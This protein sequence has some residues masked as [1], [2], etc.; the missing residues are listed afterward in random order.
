MVD[1]TGELGDE[2]EEAVSVDIFQQIKM[3][4]SLWSQNNKQFPLNFNLKKANPQIIKSVSDNR[5][6][7][8][9]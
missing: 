3:K 8:P 2:D 5:F 9:S 1:L 7:E 6:A 4:Q